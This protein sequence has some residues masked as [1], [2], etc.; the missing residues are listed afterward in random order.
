MLGCQLGRR[1]RLALEVLALTGW[2]TPQIGGQE[3]R[4]CSPGSWSEAT[5][6]PPS[7]AV[8]RTKSLG[9]GGTKVLV[10][11][12]NLPTLDT[13]PVPDPLFVGSVV[14]APPVG[15]PTDGMEL[16][17][18]LLT[19][20]DGHIHL[21]WGVAAKKPAS[22]RDVQAASVSEIWH[23][24]WSGTTW[25]SPGRVIAADQLL[26]S[27]GRIGLAATGDT[28]FVSIGGRLAP[29]GPTEVL[30]LRSVGGSRWSHMAVTRVFPAYL[31]IAAGQGQLDLAY[32]AYDPVADGN[33]VHWIRSPDSG[34]T[35]VPP[36]VVGPDHQR[37]A[38]EVLLNRVR[39]RLVLSWLSRDPSGSKSVLRSVNLPGA[40]DFLEVVEQALPGIASRPAVSAGACER[41]HLF[42]E[43]IDSSG[44]PTIAHY[45]FGDSMWVAGPVV[46]PALASFAPAAAYAAGVLALATTEVQA[47]ASGG[48]TSGTVLRLLR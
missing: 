38:K 13:S 11:G 43:V 22:Q 14:G 9:V 21:F 45:V 3:P 44:G 6:L 5:M 7:G 10:V 33:A 25:T 16:T 32:V 31:A 29:G 24:E 39:G 20:E 15:A 40:G 1:L 23:S 46:P 12:N 8:L 35:W 41:V 2:L 42:L 48:I 36:L 17:P 47:T 18:Q 30:L 19:T 4:S 37:L 26:W 34:G 28:L 27:P